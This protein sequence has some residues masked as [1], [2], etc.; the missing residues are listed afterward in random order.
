[1]DSLSVFFP[2]FNEE[3]NIKPTVEKAVKVLETLKIKNWEVIVV[4]D[5]SKDKT[6]E[7]AEKLSQKN[8]RIR[9]INQPNGG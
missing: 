8:D 7:V 1:M 4:N 3:E 9:V 5:G 2:A 6:G